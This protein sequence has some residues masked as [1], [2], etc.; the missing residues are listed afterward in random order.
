MQLI[1]YSYTA[2]L[3]SAAVMVFSFG[4]GAARATAQTTF[5]FEATYETEVNIVP[6]ISDLSA[7]TEAG[8]STDAPYGLTQYDGLVYAQ[9]DLNTGFLTFNSDPA[10]VGLEDQPFGYIVFSGSG[11]NKL[12]GTADATAQI[13]FKNL[14]AA[15]SGIINITGGEGIFTG[16]SGILDF[17]EDDIVNPEPTFPSL[18][19]V[20][21]VSGTIQ[22]VPEPGTVTGMLV[23]IGAIG[24]GVLRHRRRSHGACG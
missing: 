13:D 4:P 7:V 17:S 16:A 15:G 10:T 18:R 6:V 2:W 3:V 19:G 24:A 22:A 21:S 20:A 1:M 12:F 14:T 9:T 11:N 5:E 23:S 8:K